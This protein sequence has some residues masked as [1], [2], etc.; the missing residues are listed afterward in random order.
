MNSVSNACETLT[1]QNM[2]TKN[3]KQGAKCYGSIY[4]FS[5][6]RALDPNIFDNKT[7]KIAMTLTVRTKHI[8]R[9]VTCLI[10][11]KVSSPF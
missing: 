10:L 11:T 9:N 8:K 2:F 5:P 4:S 1:I 3:Y 6:A 7:E